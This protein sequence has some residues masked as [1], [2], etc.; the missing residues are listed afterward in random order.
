MEQLNLFTSFGYFD[1]E[2]E[3]NQ[4][5]EMFARCMKTSGTL[6]MDYLNVNFAIR[7]Q[8]E[9]EICNVDGIVYGINRWNDER[10]LYK[11]IAVY[12]AGK[13]TVHEWTKKIARLELTDF[14]R[15]F[16]AHGLQIQQV[17]GDYAL[18]PYDPNQSPRLIMIAGKA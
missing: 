11:K 14:V 10:S 7:T 13:D 15:L 17:F 5:I 9:G 1:S 12:D 18:N 4:V 16:K 8:T 3:S 2:E 6:V